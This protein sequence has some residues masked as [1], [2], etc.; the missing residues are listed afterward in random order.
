MEITGASSE[1]GMIEGWAD[2]EAIARMAQT[3]GVL[4]VSAIPR[5][6]V[7]AGSTLSEGVAIHRADSVQQLGYDGTGVTVGVISD[8]ANSLADAQASG[9]L[10]AGVAVLPGFPGTG[11]EGTAMLEIV[12]DLAP[13]A[14]LMFA[15]AEGGRASFADAIRGLAAAGCDVIVDDIGYFDEP[16]FEDGLL[17]AVIDSINADGKAYY[18]AAGNSAQDHYA[19]TFTPAGATSLHA[20]DGGTDS[21]LAITVGSGAEVI[22]VLKW[23]DPVGASAND[24][25]L[26]LS[27]QPSFA[28]PNVLDVGGDWQNG[29]G[30]PYEVVYYEN[31][32]AAMTLYL[33]VDLFEGIPRDLSLYVYDGN[34]LEYS[35]PEGSVWGHPRARGCIAV[36]A[37]NAGE[38]G[39]DLIA[40]YSSR[41]PAE[42]HFPVRE[43]RLKPD[44]TG[45]DGVLVTGTGGFGSPFYGTSAAAPHLAGLAALLL[46]ANPGWLPAQA[47]TAL[48]AAAAE[49]GD[50]G[51]DNT[52]GYG[53]ADALGALTAG[54]GTTV[55]GDLTTQTWSG[56]SS[57]YR[58]AG[59]TRIPPGET[60]TIMPGVDVVFDAATFLDVEGMLD[61][62][63]APDDS[64]SF[65][66]GAA[67]EWHGIRVT[68]GISLSYAR[69]VGARTDT[70]NV[71]GNGGALR[72]ASPTLASIEHT[73]II[74]C[75]ASGRG[76]G[77]HYSGS[78]AAL[79]IDHSILAGNG[80]PDG[81]SAVVAYDGSVTVTN[82]TFAGN[83]TNAGG[84]LEIVRGLLDLRNSIVYGNVGAP[85]LEVEGG[86]ST[87]SYSVVEGGHTGD[88]NIATNPLFV[89]AASGDYRLRATS[90]AIDA[91]DPSS[92]LDPDGSRADIGAVAVFQDLARRLEFVVAE[93]RP[94]DSVHVVMKASYDSIYSADLV[95]LVDADILT[96]AA[97]FVVS[98]AFD[99]DP[100]AAWYVET[101]GDTVRLA[102]T[103]NTLNPVTLVDETL[104]EI[105][106]EIAADSPPGSYTGISWAAFPLTNVN[107]QAATLVDGFVHVV[108]ILYGDVSGDTF[109]TA[110]DASLVMQYVVRTITV[111]D[112]A[113][114]DVTANG[115]VT[116]FDAALI[117]RKTIDPV[118]EFPVNGG[119]PLKPTTE[120]TRH[121]RWVDADGTWELR[122]N[123][124]SDV[125]AGEMEILLPHG[126]NATVEDPLGYSHQRG[127]ELRVAFARQRD[128]PVDAR[129]DLLI[130][131][132]TDI[133]MIEAPEIV[134]VELNEGLISVDDHVARA[135]QFSLAQ[136]APNPFNPTTRIRFVVPSDGVARVAIWDASGRVVRT[137]VDGQ[138]RAGVHSVVWNGRDDASRPA[139]SGVYFYRLEWT[140]GAR[141]AGELQSNSLTNASNASVRRMLLIR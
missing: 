48:L 44:I 41:G 10:P 127:T 69:M 110:Y 14:S 100:S 125:I 27:D 60:L 102:L 65:G 133:P 122:I 43:T 59:S 71:A 15:S 13:G 8:G 132:S 106:F 94:G 19:A 33:G 67:P 88:G 68:G 87:V 109:I 75:W 118:Y 6:I 82:S 37:I 46:D 107:E 137:L 31:P 54:D 66:L 1:W 131:L 99:A 95:F 105:A 113:A 17:G 12:H 74:D 81:G 89:D 124:P 25:D 11:D 97:E 42:M 141:A 72:L 3:D 96:P 29:E 39:N 85:V 49:R 55:S 20:W 2:I 83:L 126:V 136:N 16:E 114:A 86:S 115:Y 28:E 4:R 78:G 130:A 22:A 52:Y 58:I 70:A 101:S 77:I 76:G 21:A 108:P 93:G 50:P 79:S 138:V 23:N 57:P 40:Y 135:Y 63:G 98:S 123:D 120:A 139:A 45:I 30:D 111:L 61:V 24:Y 129:G 91:G 26:Y 103:T 5:A 84:V 51:P 92:P 7:R 64:V 53:L 140:G 80:A 116:S 62:Q 90:P 134:H 112:E 36:G 34:S 9:D 104:V 56:P 73:A 47:S 32:G 35:V 119:A 18:A 117:L 121:L 128:E 38:P